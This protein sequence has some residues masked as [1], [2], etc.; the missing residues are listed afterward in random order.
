MLNIMWGS[1]EKQP[2]CNS[3]LVKYCLFSLLC[4]REPSDFFIFRGK[5]KNMHF[6]KKK[7]KIVFHC[8]FFEIN[9]TDILILIFF[10]ISN[11][12]NLSKKT[13]ETLIFI[14]LLNS[15]IRSISVYVYCGW[16]NCQQTASRLATRYRRFEKKEVRNCIMLRT[17]LCATSLC[18]TG[19]PSSHGSKT[20]NENLRCSERKATR[21]FHVRKSCR[22]S[23][24]IS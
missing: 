6:Q 16:R 11:V 13:I 10:V 9:T 4:A 2:I 8:Y 23:S 20:F 15:H 14:Y 18:S 1:S 5:F 24:G 7:K 12:Y 3:A 21:G 22:F 17:T 19:G